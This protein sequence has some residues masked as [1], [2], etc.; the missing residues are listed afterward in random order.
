MSA[1]NNDPDIGD[2]SDVNKI[3]VLENSK[4]EID[5]IF[6]SREEYSRFRANYTYDPSSRYIVGDSISVF[7]VPDVFI[8]DYLEA[9]ELLT[10]LLSRNI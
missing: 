5:K 9:K 6:L 2:E 4:L 1:V 7:S 10:Y 8:A 3:I